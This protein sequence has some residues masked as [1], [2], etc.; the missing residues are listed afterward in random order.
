MVGISATRH[1]GHG[2]AFAG[3]K[4]VI[5]EKFASSFLWKDK[6][7]LNYPRKSNYYA[8]QYGQTG[9]PESSDVSE[10]EITKLSVGKRRADSGR[11]GGEGIIQRRP[12]TDARGR[13]L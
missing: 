9:N 7:S 3:V 4:K 11:D 13:K 1:L 2:G 6:N 10:V 8:G 5:W 12:T